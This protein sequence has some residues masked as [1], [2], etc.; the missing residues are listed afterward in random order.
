MVS[1]AGIACVI[2][3]IGYLITKF[4]VR[5]L[6]KAG[7]RGPDA[8]QKPVVI[9]FWMR[10][11]LAHWPKRLSTCSVFE[12]ILTVKWRKRLRLLCLSDADVIAGTGPDSN[13]NQH[14]FG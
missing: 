1:V 6:K 4:S 14:R 7:T 8:D 5:N 13:H 12:I 9:Q 11:F 10:K 3:V 2:G